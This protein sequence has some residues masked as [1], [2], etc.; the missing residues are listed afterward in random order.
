MQSMKAFISSILKFTVAASLIVWMVYNGM[1]ELSS[2]SALSNPVYFLISVI[3]VFLNIAINNIRWA[4]LLKMQ[5]FRFSARQTLPLTFIGVFFNFAIPGGVGGDV[6]KGYYLLKQSPGKKALA[7]TTLFFD[8]LMG[9][10]GMALVSAAVLIVN[11]RSIL[12]RP[13]M[14]LLAFSVIGLFSL[15]TI[16]FALSFSKSIKNLRFVDF[17][18]NKIPGGSI[19][20]KIYESIHSYRKNPRVLFQ[21]L[22]LSLLSQLAVILFVWFFA[23]ITKAPDVSFTV[24][25]FIVPLGMISMALPV[26]P[27][28]IGV[29]QAAMYYLYGLYTGID[30][31]IGPNAFT[32]YQMILFCWGLIGAYFYI[33]KKRLYPKGQVTN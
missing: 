1:L 3:L 32:A 23:I 31:Q 4:F 22:V 18:F 13:S 2:L 11:Y 27:A 29:G 7:T 33:S 21:T 10:Y 19:I 16:F 12:T 6:V 20:Q 14:R 26:T 9:M 25:L 28:G 17:L 15:I 24:Y 8:R 30:N 5:S